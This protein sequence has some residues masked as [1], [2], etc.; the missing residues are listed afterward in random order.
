M[1]IIFCNRIGIILAVGSG[2]LIG[3][4]FVFKKKGLLSSQKGK[5]AGEGLGYLKSVSFRARIPEG[6]ADVWAPGYVVDGDDHNDPWCVYLTSQEYR[7][8]TSI[9]GKYVTSR[10]THS[11]KPSWSCVDLLSSKRWRENLTFR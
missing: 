7:A 5:V 6:W 10:L 11:W 9:Q 8:P 2:V 1:I 3:T 4:S